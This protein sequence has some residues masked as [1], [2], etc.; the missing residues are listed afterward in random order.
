MSEVVNI[1]K[2][3]MEKQFD[4]VVKEGKYVMQTYSPHPTGRRRGLGSMST[5]KTRDSITIRRLGKFRAFVGVTTEYAKYAE[6]GRGS[7][8]KSYNM[9]FVGSDGRVHYATY[10]APMEGW[11]FVRRTAQI[12]RARYGR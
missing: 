11:H 3:I 9:K 6:E 7:I 8:S 10:V 2:K 1:C 12:M 4:E 5:G